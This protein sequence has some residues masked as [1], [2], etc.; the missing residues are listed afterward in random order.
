MGVRSETRFHQ[1]WFITWANVWGNTWV[2]LKRLSSRFVWRFAND[3][4]K[5]LT[6]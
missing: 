2:A 6:S 3:D 4:L 1:T 5:E